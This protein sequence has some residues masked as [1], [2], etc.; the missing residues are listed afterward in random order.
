MALTFTLGPLCAGGT[1]FDLSMELDGHEI[2]LG[3]LSYPELREPRTDEELREY[4][5]MRLRFLVSTHPAAS[6]DIILN[7]LR[8]KS[9][10]ARL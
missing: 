4:A 8:G 5:V 9:D 3:G 7:K 10:G 1:H 6:A 2:N